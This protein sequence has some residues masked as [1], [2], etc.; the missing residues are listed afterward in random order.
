MIASVCNHERLAKHGKDR[1]GN[2]RWKC[3]RCGI[4][5]VRNEHNRP[6]GDM[7][8]SMEQAEA[9]LKLLLIGG[10]S[11]RACEQLTG[12]KRDTIC[13]LVLLVGQNCDRLLRETTV[14]IKSNFVE[15]DEIWGFVGCKQKHANKKMYGPEMGDAW[16]WLAI[17]GETKLILSHATGKRDEATGDAFLAR[18]NG[19]IVGQV[20]VTSDGLAV[21]TYGVP[22]HLG[23][24]VDFAQLIKHY[25]P[26]TEVRY[27]P[28]AIS[29]IEIVP[30]FG[31]PKED[32]ISTS[33]SERLNLTV[34]MQS[35]RLTRLTNGHSKSFAHHSAMMS[36]LAAFYNFVR[37]HMS[38][39]Q[40]KVKRTPAMAAGLADHVWTI[41][42]LLVAAA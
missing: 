42:K 34:R 16:T 39:R 4:T 23:S 18:L 11:I 21:Y 24:R 22:T 5:I 2:Q 30:R 8:I 3:T 27:S 10:T 7:R 19:A 15:L 28:A 13:D 29:G 37:P 6:L 14:G 1:K 33:Y 9:V 41:R 38:L 26:Q 35:R 36:L 40:E 20:Q 31:N 12:V 17:D 32:H 25:K